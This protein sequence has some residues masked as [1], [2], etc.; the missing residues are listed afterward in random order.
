MIT[1][2]EVLD[3]FDHVAEQMQPT[4]EV[5][6]HKALQGHMVA[7]G[8]DVKEVIDAINETIRAGLLLDTGTPNRGLKKA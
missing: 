2:N 4:S 3:A 6:A 8:C 1:E 5:V 7:S